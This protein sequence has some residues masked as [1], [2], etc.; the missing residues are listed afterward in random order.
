[1]KF[2]ERGKTYYTKI[3]DIYYTKPFKTNNDRFPEALHEDDYKKR[4]SEY[5]E[6]I[7][8]ITKRTLKEKIQTKIEELKLLKKEEYVKDVCFKVIEISLVDKIKNKEYINLQ[9]DKDFRDSS[10][11]IDTKKYDVSMYAF[12][13]DSSLTEK[14]IEELRDFVINNFSSVAQISISPVNNTD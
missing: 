7:N 6:I 10:G 8:N 5:E 4:L 9:N 14:E 11:K 1:L 12:S 3:K 13:F 2:L